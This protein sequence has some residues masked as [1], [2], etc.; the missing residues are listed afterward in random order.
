MRRSKPRVPDHRGRHIDPFSA[1]DPGVKPLIDCYGVPA[2]PYGW[3]MDRRWFCRRSPSGQWPE[4]SPSD[5]YSHASQTR[6]T[7]SNV[8]IEL[9][10]LRCLMR[11]CLPISNRFRPSLTSGWLITT[12]TARIKR[13]AAPPPGKFMSRLTL[14]PNLYR[15]LS[16]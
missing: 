2:M 15:H 11:A 1:V 3:T 13:W 10:E 14:A 4:A 6:M 9:T 5:I 12:N 16:T 7:S 8:L